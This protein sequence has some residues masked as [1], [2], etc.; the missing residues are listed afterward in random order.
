MVT[1]AHFGCH[2]TFASIEKN[3]NTFVICLVF[4]CC[5]FVYTNKFSA[6]AS[7]PNW[8]GQ[9]SRIGCRASANICGGYLLVGCFSITRQALTPSCSRQPPHG[10]PFCFLRFYVFD[11]VLHA[12]F[13]IPGSRQLLFDN[14]ASADG[15]AKMIAFLGAL[16]ASQ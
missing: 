16:A 13:R 2:R 5:L 7:E 1:V 4:V 6:T 15:S 14:R 10:E 9:I 12:G 8:R 11:C 3:G